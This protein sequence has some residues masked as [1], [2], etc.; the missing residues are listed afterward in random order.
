MGCRPGGVILRSDVVRKHLFGVEP[1]D[2]LP[3]IGYHPSVGRTVYELLA[4][5]AGEVA[6]AGYV[7]I[8]DAVF[9]SEEGRRLVRETAERNGV[10]FTGI[11]LDAPLAVMERRLTARRGDAS[12]ATVDVLRQQQATVSPPAD[13]IRIDASAD[14]DAVVA[15]AGQHCSRA[16]G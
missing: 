9:G 7:A 15:D 2:P 16:V 11:W 13:W 4:R 14:I 12:D 1:A 6:T 10:P 8:V 5:S 3:P